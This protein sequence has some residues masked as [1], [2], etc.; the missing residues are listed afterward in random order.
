MFCLCFAC[1]FFNVCQNPKILFSQNKILDFCLTQVLRKQNVFQTQVKHRANI[2][3][4]NS[5]HLQRRWKHVRDSWDTWLPEWFVDSFVFCWWVVLCFIVDSLAFC[6]WWVSDVFMIHLCL[7]LCCVYVVLCWFFTSL[8]Y[9]RLLA[10]DLVPIDEALWVYLKQDPNLEGQGWQSSRFCRCLQCWCWLTAVCVST[11]TA[12]PM[13]SCISHIEMWFRFH[14][15]LKVN[16]S[17]CADLH[18]ELKALHH[19]KLD[20]TMWLCSCHRAH[21]VRRLPIGTSNIR[22]HHTHI[23]LLPGNRAAKG[24]APIFCQLATARH[25]K[26]EIVCSFCMLLDSPVCTAPTCW[27]LTRIPRQLSAC[28]LWRNIR[29]SWAL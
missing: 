22:E 2:V 25:C 7:L 27:N 12:R 17:D 29:G 11:A 9:V 18:D 1:I 5:A 21:V 13:F 28:H 4:H 10:S 3:S 19:Q 26:V 15:M 14:P 16:K 23:H 6:L 20:W 24:G 8:V